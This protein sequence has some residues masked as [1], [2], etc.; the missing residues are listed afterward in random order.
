MD[1]FRDVGRRDALSARAVVDGGLG[2]I[3]HNLHLPG[4]EIDSQQAIHE[5]V[6]HPGK[7][8]GLVK[9]DDVCHA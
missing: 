7:P 9:W 5:L 1:G 3:Q 8:P 6:V 2:H 4:R